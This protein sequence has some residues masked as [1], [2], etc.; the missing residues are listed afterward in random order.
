MVRMSQNA[1]KMYVISSEISVIR[2]R[3]C[4]LTAIQFHR[5]QVK[6]MQNLEPINLCILRA[7]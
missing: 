2:Y 5:E 3:H 1:T 6:L 4:F 7:V